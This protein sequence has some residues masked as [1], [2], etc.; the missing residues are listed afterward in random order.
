MAGLVDYKCSAELFPASSAR[1]GKVGYRRFDS[2]AEALRYAVEELSPA[3]IVGA[4]L[5]ANE[6][7]YAASEMRQLYDAE[8][9]P[10]PRRVQPG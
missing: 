3:L 7:R 9:Y 6:V 4:Y 5:E 10:L 8:A 2:L 1:R